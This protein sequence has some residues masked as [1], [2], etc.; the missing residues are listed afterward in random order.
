MAK[1]SDKKSTAKKTTAKKAV[2]K[3]VATKKETQTVETTKSKTSKKNKV[4][5]P[6]DAVYATGRRKTSIAKVWLFPGKGNITINNLPILDYIKRNV[7]VDDIQ[8]PLK[9]INILSKYDA[10]ISVNGG[11]LTGQAGATKHGL[12][13]AILLLNENHRKPLREAGLLTRD[14][15]A[16]E[17][18][19]YGKRGARKGPTYRKR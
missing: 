2:K 17:R 10:K 16:K 5:I 11:G 15:R 1:E 19:K 3:E 9:R 7:L 14:M 8:E 18:K 12:S 4:T 13:R 6:A